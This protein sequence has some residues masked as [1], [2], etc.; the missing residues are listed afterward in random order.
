VRELENVIERAVIL[1]SGLVITVDDL[2]P[3]IESAASNGRNTHPSGPT[4]PGASAGSLGPDHG[5]K[6]ADS[7]SPDRPTFSRPPSD[8]GPK[9]A[10]EAMGE[11]DPRRLFPE[12]P[13]LPEALETLEKALIGRALARSNQVQTR[14]ADLLGVKNTALHYKIK[15]H[16][17]E[18][19]G[20]DYGLPLDLNACLIPGPGLDQV[21][22][23][24]E[25]GLIEWALREAAGIQTA[26]ADRLGISKK[27]L[28][29][30]LKK[31]RLDA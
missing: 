14:A 20:R 15:K 2:P 22:E 11:L 1:C 24:V 3:E 12:L 17:P 16:R 28:Y 8:A 26:A 31:Y 5:S 25:K 30:K 9:D 18:D 7:E 13:H 21:I 19:L 10:A 29:Y 4:D 6:T 27:L 23:T